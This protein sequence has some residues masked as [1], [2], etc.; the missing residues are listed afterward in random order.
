M[1][2]MTKEDIV[3]ILGGFRQRIGLSETQINEIS[4]VLTDQ[5][6]A[7][8]PDKYFRCK[9][10]MHGAEIFKGY[11]KVQCDHCI[12]ESKPEFH[13]KPIATKTNH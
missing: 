12:S 10:M 5:I 4:D 3:R 6:F 1:D 9:A 7:E 11:C 13:Q 8:K 2:V